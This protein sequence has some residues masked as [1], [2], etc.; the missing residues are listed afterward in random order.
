MDVSKTEMTALV[1]EIYAQPLKLKTIPVPEVVTGSALIKVLAAPVLSYAREVYNG[2]RKYSYNA[3]LVPGTSCVGRVTALGPDSTVLK[4]GQLVY[5]D[6]TIHSRDNPDDM[7]LHGLTAAATPGS[8]KLMDVWRDGTYAEYTLV[9]LEAV[10]PVDEERMRALGY[11]HND[12]A[13]MGKHLVPLGGLRDINL[14]AGETIVVAPATG[15][16]GGAAVACAMAMGASVIAMGRNEASLAALES[17]FPRVKTV[18]ITSNVEGDVAALQAAACGRSIDAVFEIS[19]PA[20]AK[21]THIKSCILALRRGGRLS[22]MGGIQEDVAI[23]LRQVMRKNLTLRG[24]WMYDREQVHALIKMVETGILKIGE[25][26][27]VKDIGVFQFGEWE[28]AFDVA[29]E[30]ARWDAAVV[31]RP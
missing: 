19:P 17:A 16:F 24:T 1:Q 14:Q 10:F 7:I 20:A 30:N 21:S 26:S 2:T 31:M 22:L 29:S 27:G 8:E 23:P 18:Q 13:I 6:A 4:V 28:K 9:P 15:A 11:Q 25:Q 5:A 3:P 12:I